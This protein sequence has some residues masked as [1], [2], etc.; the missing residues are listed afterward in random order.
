MI[1]S[2]VVDGLAALTLASTAAGGIE[3]TFVPG[4]GMVGCSLRHRGDEL[5]GQRRGLSAYV[6][7]RATMGIPLLHPWANRLGRRHFEVA[8]GE[9]AIDPD[10]TPVRLD[11]DGLPMHGLLSAATG[12]QVERH[13]ALADGAVLG[14]RFDFAADEAL[15]AAF[16]FAHE[17]RFEAALVGPRLTITTTVRASGETP[18]P[19]AFGYHPYLRL[20]G[21]AREDWHVEAP[22]REQLRLDAQMLPTGE[23][24]DAEVFAGRLGARTFDAAFVAPAGGAPFVLAGNDRRIELA[25]LAGY[26]YAQVFAPSDDDVI[27]F[28]P[29]TAPTNALVDGGAEL[30]VLA[31]GESYH[32]GFSI[33]LA[34]GA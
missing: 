5:L 28:E 26:P 19:I 6:A 21:V 3:A 2:R 14:A 31:P 9:V 17:L 8:G 34:G 4:A 15:I 12:W 30:P 11:A 25:F 16:P 23:R 1:G 29:M 22:V 13:D 32:A 10:L 33:T 27:A 18:V 7:H 20:P 24:F